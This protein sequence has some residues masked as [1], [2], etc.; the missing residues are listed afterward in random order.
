MNTETPTN[1][2]RRSGKRG[3]GEG[4]VTQ[5][6]DG[7][8]QARM[9]LE[10]GKR[11]AYYGTTR[12]E[13][14]QKLNAAL[15]DRDRGLPIVGEVQT[16]EQYLLSW[17]DMMQPVLR[18]RT[19]KVYREL[20]TLHA[21]P[22]LGKTRLARLSAQQI[23]ALYR[24]TLDKGRS[25]T[26]VHHLGTVLHGALKQAERLGLVPR[27]VCMLVEL[28]RIAYHEPQALSRDQVL[29][30]LRAAQRHPM[31]ALFTLAVTT[32]MREGELLALRWRD[33][34]LEHG[35]LHVR[36]TLRR[37]P[38]GGFS[39]DPPKSKKSQRLL[40]LPNT[41]CLLLRR[42]RARLAEA[43]LTA[44]S[45]WQDYDLVF[46][47]TIGTPMDAISMLRRQFW[48][49]LSQA[50]LPRIRFHDLR[51]TAATLLLGPV[52]T[53]VASEYLGHSS[54]GITEN[55]YQHV[56]P[57]MQSY[58][59]RLGPRRLWICLGH[60]WK[61]VVERIRS[62][63]AWKVAQCANWASSRSSMVAKCWLINAALVSGHKCS[64]GCNSGE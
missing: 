51:H 3:N 6:S 23:Q 41:I 28:P 8:W 42:H 64:A 22:A 27:N 4:S 21:I 52:P 1:K 48:P 35:T 36:A 53:K 16:V 9:T 63:R 55:T 26:T 59:F 32:G 46:P 56:I 10:D 31:E 15:R 57:G 30:L 62:G 44:G 47:T 2:T 43:R 18:P 50:G 60:Q 25:P 20:L 7:R 17:L 24:S 37:V 13:A 39:F 5:L 58:Q 14:A 19:Y 29:T 54:T 34:D 11:K 45:E 33:V 12:A 40:M 38:G 61:Q 49:F